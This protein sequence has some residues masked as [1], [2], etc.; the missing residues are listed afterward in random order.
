[1]VEN[2]THPY[3]SLMIQIFQVELP[4]QRRRRR[5]YKQITFTPLEQSTHSPIQAIPVK[6]LSSTGELDPCTLKDEESEADVKK[7]E[8]GAVD[9]LEL[10]NQPSLEKIIEEEETGE[11]HK[12]G[13]AI[14]GSDSSDSSPE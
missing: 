2:T 14:L 1:M 10:Q 12:D 11:S 5:P 3:L 8:G 6:K 13:I 4:P 7:S 9:E